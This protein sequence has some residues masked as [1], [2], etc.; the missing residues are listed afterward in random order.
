[1]LLILWLL[2]IIIGK[3][4]FYYFYLPAHKVSRYQHANNIFGSV[5]EIG[6]HRGKYFLAIAGNALHSETLVA[7]DLFE[8]GQSKNFDKSGKGNLIGFLQQT[9]L[10]FG[11]EITKKIKIIKGDSTELTAK[12]FK[13][14]PKFRY[15]SIDGGHSLQTTIS[16][17]N[18]V[19]CMIIDGGIIVVDDYQNYEWIGV[20]DAIILY[21]HS[22]NKLVPIMA[23]DNKLYLTTSNYAKFYIDFMHNNI[24]NI[25]CKNKDIHP[26][27]HSIRGY[28][29]CYNGNF[30]NVYKSLKFSNKTM[31]AKINHKNEKVN[32]NIND[33]YN[34]LSSYCI[35]EGTYVTTV[36]NGNKIKKGAKY[37]INQKVCS[38]TKCNS[39]LL[40][41]EKINNLTYIYTNGSHD[42]NFQNYDIGN[43]N[44]KY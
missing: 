3:L 42:T 24:P 39:D 20:T 18:L 6:I 13:G 28:P 4:S 8:D 15:F 2:S 29:I 12:S 21:L 7:I 41:M 43:K 10:Y 35:P 5:G 25:I 40:T 14:I 34:N 9:E 44:I 23:I 37:D 27:M 16:D 38:T 32:I 26:A 30:N 36:Y 19:A 31:N 11:K 1:M 22:Q 33:I 17:L